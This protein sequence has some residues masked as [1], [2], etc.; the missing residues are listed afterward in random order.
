MQIIFLSIVGLK[1]NFKQD[2]SQ[3]IHE[4]NEAHVKIRGLSFDTKETIKSL[5]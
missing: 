5:A 3:Q 2:I 4:L 1:M